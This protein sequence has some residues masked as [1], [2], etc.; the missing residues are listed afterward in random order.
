MRSKAFVALSAVSLLITLLS[1]HAVGATAPDTQPATAPADTLKIAILAPLSVLQ[2]LG[3]AARDG[4]LLAIEQQ[5]ASGGIL[6]MTILPIIEDTACDATLAVTATNKVID[7]DGAYIIGDVCSISSI[8][9]SEIANA[10]DV[11]QMTPS[12]TNPQVTLDLDGNVRPYTFRA[13]F[14]DPFQGAAAARFARDSL[15]AQKAFIMLDPDNPYIKGLADA[16][17]AEFSRAGAIVG[18]EVFTQE[19]TDFAAILAAIA[20]ADPDVVY[21]PSYVNTAN[22]VTQQAKAMGITVPF[23]GGDG[24]DSPELDVTTAAGSY[25]INHLSFEDPRPEVAAFEQAFT[26]R[27]AAPP[28]YIAALAYDSAKLLF[29]AMQEAGTTDTAAVQAQLEAISFQ[30]VTGSL[31]YDVSHNPAKSAFVISVQDDGVHFHSLV[32]PIEPV[33]DLTINYSSGSQGSWFTL[34]G[35]NY[36]PNT[37]GSITINGDAVGDIAVDGA[38]GFTFVL[39]TTG[40]ND[41]RYYVTVT[42]NPSATSDFTLDAAEPLRPLESDPGLPTIKLDPIAFTEFTY[43]PLALH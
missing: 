17:Q 5:N 23:M 34:T 9:I 20:L 22:L 21:L 14:I 24:W 3:E 19:T 25:F 42:V 10:A 29:Q 36:P 26:A 16:F 43:L 1:G 39:D 35:A 31:F 7:Q 30:G 37:T 15:L 11:I 41:G 32:A 38:G 12:A 40:A 6:G 18:K 33:A 27:F 28:T 8:P 13:C 2:E 4:A